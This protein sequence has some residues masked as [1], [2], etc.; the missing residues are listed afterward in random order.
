MN[1][2]DRYRL[3]S[4]NPYFDEETRLEVR[5]ITDPQEIE[6]R[7]YT[8]LE[9]G[10]GGL[11]GI[12]GAGTNRMNKYV[13][14][15]VTQGL[16][17]CVCDHGPEGMEQGVVIAH[18]SRRY[19]P[20]FALEAALVLAQN[21]IK[22]YLFDA[23]RPTP[24]LSFAVRQLK[25]LAG[26]VITA[27]HNP[28]TYNGYKVYWEDGGQVPP[29]KAD[30]ILAR[31]EARENW[32]GIE[33]MSITEAKQ[34]GLLQIIGEEIDSTY[35]NRVKSLALHPDLDALKGG[36]LKI[37]YT[38]LHGAGNH[39]VRRALSELGFSSVSVVREQENPDPDFTTVPYPN[40]EI[41]AT[42]ELA[43]QYGR[44]LNADLLLAT[45]PDSD[46]LGVALRTH[47]GD[48]V[49]LTGNQIG[50]VLTYYVLSQKKALG[51]LPDN[52]A[53]IKTVASTDL[54]DEVAHYFQARV[55]NVLTGFKFIAE[56]EK[57]MEEGGWG[58]FQFGFEESYG[59]LAGDFVRDKDAIIASVILAEAA[60]YYQEVEGINFFDVLEN[61]YQKFGYYLDDQ[62]SLVLAGK[63]GKEE[64]ALI[65]DSFRQEEISQLSGI[66]V[67][68]IDDYE[69]RVRKDSTTGETYDLQLPRSN[70]LRYSF[71]G[72]GFVMVRPSGTE[73]KI[74][75]YFSV[76]ADNLTAAKDSLTK[77]KDEVM[78]RIA[79]I[80][81]V[82]EA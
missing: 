41:P 15:K 67:A 64:M 8:D 72:G 29:T 1:I 43:K 35:L 37:V 60:L 52:A 20:E 16:A 23:L 19:S 82:I 22:V 80:R 57:E 31:I 44:K 11:R 36:K 54:A 47:Q 9:F 27:S 59:Y 12:I 39:L 63:R 62:E 73:P 50:V 74:K 51:A 10:T 18:D 76:K 5:G 46:R 21:G 40:P 75:F 68:K 25:A 17:E 61:I 78:N 24:E 69:R 45:D 34:Q 42:F 26:I 71:V 81:S 14:R 56:K 32:L 70:V 13:I 30:Q 53:I 28:K 66:P 4:E 6:D 2:E 79:K 38:P 48:Y 58:T 65:M 3:W 7:F 49:Q 77:V 33:P 55:E